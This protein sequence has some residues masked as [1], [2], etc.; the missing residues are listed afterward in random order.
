MDE[1]LHPQEEQILRYLDGEMTVGEKTAFE[2]QLASD[3]AL[4]E[5]VEAMR[6]SVEAAALYGVHT[7]VASIHREAVAQYSPARK[8]RVVPFRRVV[9]YTMA[10]A[11]SILLVFIAVQGYRFY[12]LTPEGLYEDSFIAY[13]LSPVRGD[14]PGFT[15]LEKAY[16]EEQYSMVVRMAKEKGRVLTPRE[17]FVAGLSSLQLNDASAAIPWFRRL[18]EPGNPFQPDAGFYLSLAYLK[19]KDYDRALS[20]MQ[21]IRSNPKHPYHDRITRRM[22]NDTKM[23][24]WK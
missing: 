22:I 16:S 10:V 23:L 7:Q 20:L 5:Q 11:A 14:E 9:R 1:S 13:N 15:N 17:V 4:R 19:D 24:K 3:N 8:G 2:A 6:F 12:N 18:N 21:K